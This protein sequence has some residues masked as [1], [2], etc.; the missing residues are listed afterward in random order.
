MSVVRVEY[1]NT[2]TH[3]IS[4][5]IVCHDPNKYTTHTGN[6]RVQRCRYEPNR[7]CDWDWGN[8]GYMMPFRNLEQAIEYM[9][10]ASK[11][12]DALPRNWS[13]ARYRVYDPDTGESIP[14]EAIQ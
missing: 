7:D 4:K 14:L 11:G 1:G 13:G 3:Y 12:T 10:F 6:W 8:I 9:V 5:S 2:G